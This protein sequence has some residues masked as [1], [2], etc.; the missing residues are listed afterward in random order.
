MTIG[1][2]STKLSTGTETVKTRTDFTSKKSS[3]WSKGTFGKAETE[4]IQF[5][6]QYK[7]EFGA[8][9]DNKSFQFVYEWLKGSTDYYKDIL[10]VNTNNALDAKLRGIIAGQKE[11]ITMLDFMR[12]A[13]NKKQEK[14]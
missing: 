8:F 1:D 2:T 9:I 10:S 12:N 13:A 4:I 6:E 14:K 11:L 5:A 3:F 7:M